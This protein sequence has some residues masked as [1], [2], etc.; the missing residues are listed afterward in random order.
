MKILIVEDEAWNIFTISGCL[1]RNLPEVEIELL[2]HMTPLPWKDEDTFKR[3]TSA[4]FPTTK[5]LISI[6]EESE[7]DL[8]LLDY[9]LGNYCVT[10]SIINAC[11]KNG[12][13][14]I[15]IGSENKIQGVSENFHCKSSIP[16]P[17]FPDE[18]DSRQ[19]D[20]ERDF[21]SMIKQA[22]NLV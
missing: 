5:E 18:A 4:T 13:L 16:S 2:P 1:N 19:L 20:I 8:V 10:N 22:L 14:V 15:G 11:T 21:V 7:A 12:R 6:V 17:V 3:N 9:R